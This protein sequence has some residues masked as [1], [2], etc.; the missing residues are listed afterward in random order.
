MAIDI[1][2]AIMNLLVEQSLLYATRDRNEKDIAVDLQN[3]NRKRELHSSTAD[4]AE[5]SETSSLFYPVVMFSAVASTIQIIV[6]ASRVLD[7]LK[8]NLQTFEP[9]VQN[10]WLL[11]VTIILC[12]YDFDIDLWL[13]YCG[14][15]GSQPDRH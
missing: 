2:G 5:A 14:H 15:D 8:V 6:H 13:R 11:E 4:R 1:N 12:W 10:F 9:F 3:S 7:L